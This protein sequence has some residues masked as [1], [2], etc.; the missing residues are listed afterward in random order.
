MIAT[1][2]NFLLLRTALAGAFLALAALLLFVI[3]EHSAGVAEAA[4]KTRKACM[5]NGAV[6]E[7]KE[8]PGLVADCVALLKARDTL[9]DSQALNWSADVSHVQV[10]RSFYRRDV[11]SRD[12]TY[13]SRVPGIWMAAYH[14]SWV[15][16]PN[17]DICIWGKTG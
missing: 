3:P 7:P 9:R 16:S 2:F 13:L 8:N 12:E 1:R 6:P 14:R 15:T 17:S 10:G 5:K 11:A 4:Q